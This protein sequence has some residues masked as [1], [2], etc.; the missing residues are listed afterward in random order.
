M[1]PAALGAR[2]RALDHDQAA[3]DVG[4]DDL[5]VL[6][7][8]AARTHVPGHLLVLE[9]LAGVLAAA[10]RTDRA[11]RDRHAVRGAQPAEVPALHAAGETLADR[12]AG[13]VHQL[14]LE[15]VVGL[16][17][18][19]DID[20]VVRIDAELRD[21]ALGLHL[22]DRELAAL[23]LGQV[24]RLGGAGAEL[25]GD[26][27]VLLARALSHDLAVVQPEHRH[28]DVRA[29]RHEDAGHAQLLCDQSRTH[30]LLP[31]CLAPVRVLLVRGPCRGP[32]GDLCS[33]TA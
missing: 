25:H 18:G 33:T 27:A 17:R 30:R 4:P 21:M 20:E 8:D 10:G 6:R 15:E 11:V 31:S 13:D 5:D 24:L 22:G 26:V 1:D 16:Q 32:R 2:N 14:P 28:G 3:L 12:G 19:A 7:G 9:G 29:V 23:G